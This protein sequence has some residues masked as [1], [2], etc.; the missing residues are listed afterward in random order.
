MGFW[1]GVGGAG[2]ACGIVGWVAHTF[3]ACDA[4]VTGGRATRAFGGSH[5]EYSM[6][7]RWGW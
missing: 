7:E 3:L 4:N 1:A 6:P 2:S 5:V